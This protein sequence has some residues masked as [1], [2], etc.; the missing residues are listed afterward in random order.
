MV[1]LASLFKEIWLDL[2]LK[3]NMLCNERG[4]SIGKEYDRQPLGD[5]TT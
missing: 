3:K 4:P 1:S 5:D 2:V